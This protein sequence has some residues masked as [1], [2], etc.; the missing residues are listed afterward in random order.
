MT[1]CLS[2]NSSCLGSCNSSRTLADPAS[3]PEREL[4]CRTSGFHGYRLNASF[5]VKQAI[6]SDAIW[7]MF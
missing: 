6:E 2:P 5:A 3:F 4:S 1:L 7:G